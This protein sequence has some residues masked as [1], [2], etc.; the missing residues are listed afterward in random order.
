MNAKDRITIIVAS[1]ATGSLKIP[2]GAIGKAKNPKC[3]RIRPCPLHYQSQRNAWADGASFKVWFHKC[4]LPAVR[5]FTSEKVLL[6]M[7]D[8]GSHNSN[9]IDNRSQVRILCL[10]PNCTSVHQPMDM[11]IIA[12][13][14]VKYRFAVISRPT[15]T[16]EE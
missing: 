12:A 3:F 10:P 15:D 9:E 11:G 5:K 6:I 8:A 13:I 16:F 7:D 14:K 4:F 1:N 2:L